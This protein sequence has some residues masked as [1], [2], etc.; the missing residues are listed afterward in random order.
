M[1]Y[2]INIFVLTFPLNLNISDA[3]DPST[4]VSLKTVLKRLR[5]SRKRV[6]RRETS[7]QRRKRKTSSCRRCS[8]KKK[9]LWNNL[10]RSSTKLLFHIWLCKWPKNFSQMKNSKEIKSFRWILKTCKS[11]VV[12]H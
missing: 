3:F 12:K 1:S 8:N 7:W 4:S 2:I 11:I 9:F 5:L 6:R 10:N